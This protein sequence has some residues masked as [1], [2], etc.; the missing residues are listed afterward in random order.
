M[1]QD[2]LEYHVNGRIAFGPVSDNYV[3][4]P[5]YQAKPAWE[6]VRMEIVRGTL[7]TEIRQYFHRCA[8]L[9]LG[10]AWHIVGARGQVLSIRL[11]S[12]AQLLGL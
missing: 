1:T 10:C 3:F 8:G 2:F 5:K 11:C 12:G 7:M 9:R 4:M 6:A